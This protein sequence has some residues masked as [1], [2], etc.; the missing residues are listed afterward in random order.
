MN[1]Y[2]MGFVNDLRVKSWE[3]SS[4]DLESIMQWT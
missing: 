1:S 4:M 3:Q 2:Y